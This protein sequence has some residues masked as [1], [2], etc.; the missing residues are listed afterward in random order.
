M[1]ID[2]VAAAVVRI[3]GAVVS[4]QKA[5]IRHDAGDNKGTFCLV[6]VIEEYYRGALKWPGRRVPPSAWHVSQMERQILE[7]NPKSRLARGHHGATRGGDL[8]IP[9]AT[10][11]RKLVLVLR[12]R[13]KR[14]GH[15]RLESIHRHESLSK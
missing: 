15:G 11:L 8:H 13:A 2:G 14:P 6:S 10:A 4:H 12:Q 1:L 9:G 5:W 3:S 7:R